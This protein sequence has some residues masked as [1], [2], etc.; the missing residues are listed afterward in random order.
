[1]KI[2]DEGY[3]K[4][5]KR[6]TLLVDSLPDAQVRIEAEQVITALPLDFL[7]PHISLHLNNDKSAPII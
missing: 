3:M 2:K 7:S 1:M 6:K 4:T 5:N